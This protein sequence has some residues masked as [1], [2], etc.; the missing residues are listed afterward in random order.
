MTL[1]LTYDNQQLQ[2]GYGAQLMRIIGIYSLAKKFRLHYVHSPILET[3]E[4]LAHNINNLEELSLLTDQVNDF[5]ALPSSTDRKIFDEVVSV[6]SLGWKFF[7]KSILKYQFSKK[8]VLIRILLPF[9][10]IERIPNAYAIGTKYIKLANKDLFRENLANEIVVHVRMS[11]GQSTTISPHVRPRFLPT[12]Y[13]VD[14]LRA[15]L[16]L[17]PD[18]REMK[19]LVHTDMP[20]ISRTWTPTAKRLQQNIEFG[21]KVIHG[22]INVIGKDLSKRFRELG[23]HKLEICYE[24]Q[25]LVAFLDMATAGT[26]IMSR[27]SFSYLAALFNENEV[28]WPSGYW[29]VKLRKWKQS[30]EFLSTQ[31]YEL[32]PG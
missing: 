32:I 25:F 16:S 10:V 26:L 29:H 28:V 13:Y 14:L 1:Y 18:Q 4:E 15:R 20:N 3:V 7:L 12:D 8:N 23:C 27:S 17:N 24:S 31:N 11:Y 2:D 6:K 19:I 5:F 22:K 30:G 21:E 9:P